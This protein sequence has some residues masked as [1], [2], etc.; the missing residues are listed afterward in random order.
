[1]QLHAPDNPITFTAHEVTQVSA[2]PGQGFPHPPSSSYLEKLSP[3][4]HLSNSK[5][6]IW[7]HHHTLCS[8]HTTQ[9]QWKAYNSLQPSC[10]QL[11]HHP[12]VS[13]FSTIPQVCF[14]QETL[15]LQTLLHPTLLLGPTAAGNFSQARG[16]LG[17]AALLTKVQACPKTSPLPYEYLPHTL[18]TYDI[19]TSIYQ[20]LRRI[21]PHPH[22]TSL[23]PRL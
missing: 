1:M 2:I 16:T 13:T 8:T 10:A 6:S 17:K 23:F 22:C 14:K 5:S 9:P 3:S 20:S 19:H 12:P 21:L 4:K 15:I 11:P 7:K 18:S